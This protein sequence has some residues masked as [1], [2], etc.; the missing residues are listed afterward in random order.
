MLQK[1]QFLYEARLK[2]FEQHY[3]LCRHQIPIRIEVKNL[4]TD[5]V[6]EFLMNF[7]RGSNLMEKYDKFSKIPS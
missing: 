7:K 5:S 2:Y 6:F 1:S 3:Q 4:G